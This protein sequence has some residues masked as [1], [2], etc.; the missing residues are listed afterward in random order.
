[1]PDLQ[2]KKDESVTKKRINHLGE[3]ISC[4][5][6]RYCKITLS[7]IFAIV[8]PVSRN[9]KQLITLYD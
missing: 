4:A 7:I 6:F 9:A 5:E 3:V 8:T 2:F 1:M